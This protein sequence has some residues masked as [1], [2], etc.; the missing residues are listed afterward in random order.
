VYLS[1]IWWNLSYFHVELSHSVLFGGTLPHIWWSL[2][3]SHFELSHSILTSG[4]LSH[5]GVADQRILLVSL[6]EFFFLQT[7]NN[8]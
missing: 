1:N 7:R 5:M 2:S 4:T 3:S 6:A 8:L